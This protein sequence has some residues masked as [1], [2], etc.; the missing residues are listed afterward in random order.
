MLA[1]WS[2]LDQTVTILVNVVEALSTEL[3]LVKLAKRV[4]QVGE[5]LWKIDWLHGRLVA[6]R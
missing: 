2:N 4:E 1:F 6:L 5:R 3:L